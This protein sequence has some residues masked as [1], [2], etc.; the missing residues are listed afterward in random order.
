M[1]GDILTL[2]LLVGGLLLVGSEF[3]MPA[4]VSLF[5]GLGALLTAG[6]RFIGL[7]DSL[8]ASLLTFAVSSLVMVFGL[9]RYALKIFP[10]EVRK[11]DI[12]E[13]RQDF[14]QI[15]EVLD[16]VHEDKP[17]GRI[18]YQGTTWQATSTDGV[19][20]KGQQARIVVRDNLVWVVE[21]VPSEESRLLEE[22]TSDG[23]SQRVPT[24]S[25][26]DSS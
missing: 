13:A 1:S 7:I 19:I 8:P 21:P 12:D 18:R 3:V 10:P 15:V 25:A 16:D 6:L 2:I 17:V 5:F 9:R 22:S 26:R 20:K 24:T 14:G 11:A 23:L 4:M